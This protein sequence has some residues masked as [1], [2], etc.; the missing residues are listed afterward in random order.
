MAA[1]RNILSG[2]AKKSL[3]E[4]RWGQYRGET[5]AS[6]FEAGEGA[7]QISKWEGWHVQGRKQFQGH[8]EEWTE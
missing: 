1:W 2:Q 8:A 4:Q 5:G 3:L 6:V 7:L